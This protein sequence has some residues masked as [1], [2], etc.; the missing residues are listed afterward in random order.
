MSAPAAVAAP[1]PVDD[2]REVRGWALYSWADHAFVTTVATVLIGPFLLS[3]ATTAVG[4]RGDVLS[5]GPL[6][7]SAAGFPSAVLTASVVAQIFVL[8]VFGAAADTLPAKRRLLAWLTAAG[9][10]LVALLAAAGGSAWLYAGLLFV[11]ANVVFGAAD[12][13][14][15]AFLPEIASPDRRDATSSVG[16]AYG[17]LGGGLLLAVNLALLSLPG[18]LGLSRGQAVRVVFVVSAVWWLGFGALALRRLRTRPPRRSGA[19]GGRAATGLR[20]LRSALAELRRMPQSFRFLVAYLLYSDAIQ[21]VVG[22]ASTYIT[23]ELF[24]NDA[25]KAATFLFAL[26]L[27]IQF[28]AIGGSLAA[29]RLAERYGTK[30]V[31]LATLTVWIAVVLYAYAALRST[32][33]AVVLGVAMAV[34]LGGSQSLSR[35]LWSQMI[36][37]GREATYFGLYAIADRGTSWL[38]PLVFT[39]TVTYTG[40]FRQAILTLVAFFALGIAVLART[41]VDAARRE[42]GRAHPQPAVT[43]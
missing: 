14:Y 30:Q 1:A 42:A 36:P 37:P 41:D 25:E 11:A 26:I 34:V 31:V 5:L 35:S 13:V 4:D 16:Y 7:V 32:W 22:L 40:S 20:E 38:A 18:A 33:E 29:A 28:V 12:V 21:A 27:L 8:P 3:L 2:R 6:R 43:P 24:G 15:N 9:S 17:Y 19:G 23:A 10:V 39:V